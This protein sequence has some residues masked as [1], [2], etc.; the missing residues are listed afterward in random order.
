MNKEIL[1]VC[2]FNAHTNSNLEIL[3]LLR[4]DKGRTRRSI[5]EIVD[6]F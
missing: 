1:K 5:D 2:R 4:G 3:S 6:K